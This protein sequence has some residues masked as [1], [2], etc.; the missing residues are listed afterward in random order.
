MNADRMERYRPLIEP[1]IYDPTRFDTY[2]EQLGVAYPTMETD[3]TR[4]R[5]TNNR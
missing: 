2:L 3:S 5:G 1:N 4:L